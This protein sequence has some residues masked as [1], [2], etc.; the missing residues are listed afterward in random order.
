MRTIVVILIGIALAFLWRWALLRFG[1]RPAMS[2]VSFALAWVLFCVVDIY[3]GVVHAGY[4]LIEELIIHAVI[5]I[6]PLSVWWML[7][8]LGSPR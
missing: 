7:D 8:R 5:F 2:W 4:G 3:I 6:V 1:V